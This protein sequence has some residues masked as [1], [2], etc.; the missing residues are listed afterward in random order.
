MYPRETRDAP[1]R[2]SPVLMYPPPNRKRW[3]GGTSFL[4]TV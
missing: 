2:G 4:L 3:H 1:M